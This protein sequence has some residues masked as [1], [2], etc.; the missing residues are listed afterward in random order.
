M[1]IFNVY[2][3]WEISLDQYDGGDTS[4]FVQNFFHLLLWL[5][6]KFL[7]ISSLVSQ[8]LKLWTHKGEKR[9]LELLAELGLPLTECKQLF[10]G[11]DV[12]LRTELAT[13][14]EGGYWLG[15]FNAFNN[16]AYSIS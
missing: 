7:F 2:H 3:N 16:I 1:I 11:M 4:Q 12:S 13:L 14:L 5:M 6:V 10:C 15:C 9:M 8:S